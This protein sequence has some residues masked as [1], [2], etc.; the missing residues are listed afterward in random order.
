MCPSGEITQI[1]QQNVSQQRR[2]HLPAHRIGVVPQKIRQLQ[3]L[4]DLLEKHFDLPAAAVEVGDGAR[5]PLQVVGQK[6]HLPFH[7]LDL[8]QR[9]HPPHQL[10]GGLVGVAQHDDFIQSA[11]IEV[12]GKDGLSQ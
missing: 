7:V 1:A 10:R 11:A 2:P 8:H 12:V 9:H 3:G 4:L 5:A 6:H